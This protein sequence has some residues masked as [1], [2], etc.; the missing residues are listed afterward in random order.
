MPLSD[1]PAAKYGISEHWLSFEGDIHPLV[2]LGAALDHQK[3]LGQPVEE[4]HLVAHGNSCGIELAGQWVDHAQL[5]KHAQN[6]NGWGI[7]NY[8]GCCHI[9]LNKSF[10]LLLEDL[11]GADIFSNHQEI[12]RFHATVK[13]RHGDK[14]RLEDIFQEQAIIKWKG[15]LSY[16]Q[17]GQDLDGG[18]QNEVFGQT[19]N[20]SDD[21]LTIAGGTQYGDGN[22]SESGLVR[23]Y[24]WHSGNN[25]WEQRGGVIEGQ[26]NN[27]IGSSVA[28]SANGSTIAIGAQ[29]ADTAV[30]T[31]TGCVRIY[32]WNSGNNQW[33]QIGQDIAGEAR[34]DRFGSAVSL[35]D[36][37]IVAT[38]AFA[39]DGG[40]NLS[41]HVRVHHG[42]QVP[43]SG[44]SEAGY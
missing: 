30:D 3:R 32:N 26:R 5:L 15:N 9:G 10:I 29:T 27:K 35:N 13:N 4:L 6:L 34:N 1:L 16:N 24:R 11:T 28:L 40:G 39:N 36:G 19:F 14:K 22:G 37:S 18:K 42:I 33:V 20:I 25:R 8:A 44:S 17:L 43:I 41:G 2:Q 21:G 23:V 31:K 38:A 7:R 12:N